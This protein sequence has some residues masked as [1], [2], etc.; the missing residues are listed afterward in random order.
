MTA[1]CGPW[2]LYR[3]A[4]AYLVWVF[5]WRRRGEVMWWG[6][7]GWAHRYILYRQDLLY[8]HVQY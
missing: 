7:G 4:S 1:S 3:R 8:I 5:G 6:Y 2:K